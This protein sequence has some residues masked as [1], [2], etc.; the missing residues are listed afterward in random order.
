M[1]Q[2][3]EILYNPLRRNMLGI[4]LNT[5]PFEQQLEIHQRRLFALYKLPDSVDVDISTISTHTLEI[6]CREIRETISA[7]DAIRLNSNDATRANKLLLIIQQTRQ[8]HDALIL[9]GDALKLGTKQP[10]KARE[11][12]Y[13]K[14]RVCQDC[15]EEALKNFKEIM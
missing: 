13:K 11:T 10:L 5:L 8:A 9:G 7:L 3:E 15:L 14:I 4:D 2:P 6:L 12:L 1:A